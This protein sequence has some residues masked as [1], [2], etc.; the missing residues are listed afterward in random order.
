MMHQYDLEDMFYITEP[1]CH[2]SQQTPASRPR[3]KWSGV[4]CCASYI[5]GVWL[6]YRL[7]IIINYLLIMWELLGEQR[8]GGW[9]HGWDESLN[10]NLVN[11][12]FQEVSVDAESV[13][14]VSFSVGVDVSLTSWPSDLTN[15]WY[16]QS[17]CCFVE[18]QEEFL[19][20]GMMM[21]IM[22]MAPWSHRNQ[23]KTL[24]VLTVRQSLSSGRL[25]GV[26]EGF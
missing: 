20:G 1:W 17:G 14:V 15:L 23:S 6:W 5:L 11:Y 19:I 9:E 4:T 10:D 3:F 7:L 13:L 24:N 12:Y 18:V 16:N 2:Q 22:T 21:M 25:Q 8:H 26:L